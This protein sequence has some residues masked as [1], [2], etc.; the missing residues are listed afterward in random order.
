[1]EMFKQNDFYGIITKRYPN[2]DVVVDS[3]G[4]IMTL[5]ESDNELR[6]GYEEGGEVMEAEI[7][8]EVLLAPNGKPS[9][10]G[11]RQWHLVRTP[12]FKQWFGDWENSPESASKMVDL[13]GEP[14]V[15]Y[16]GTNQE[17]TVFRDDVGHWHDKGFYG[18]GFY[19]T[20]NTDPKWMRMAIGEAGY[21]GSKVL[22]CFIKTNTPFDFSTLTEYN[23]QDISYMGYDAMVFLYNIAKRFPELA[24]TITIPQN[25]WNSTLQEN[26]VEYLPISVIPPLVDKYKKLLKIRPTFENNNRD[27]VRSGYVKS[28]IIEY[29]NTAQGGKKDSWVSADWLGEY[30]DHLSD[31]E[32]EIMLIIDAIEKYDGLKA[33]YH[34]EGYTT[35][36]PSITDA[37]KKSHDGIKQGKSGDEIVVFESTQIKLADGSNKTFDGNNPDI[38]YV[39]GGSVG[40]KFLSKTATKK[41]LESTFKNYQKDNMSL[42]EIDKRSQKVG[43]KAQEGWRNSA[44]YKALHDRYK[45]DFEGESKRNPDEKID[46]SGLNHFWT[47]ENKERKRLEA[48]NKYRTGSPDEMPI[49]I[50][51]GLPRKF[52]GKYVASEGQM[53]LY[54]FPT[55]EPFKE[56]GVS[57]FDGIYDG[58]GKFV[59][60][61]TGASNSLTIGYNEASET[62]RPLYLVEGEI[63]DFGADDE[64]TLDPK[65]IKVI[66][67][68]DPK[69]VFNDIYS[70]AGFNYAGEEVEHPHTE[71]L[72]YAKGGSVAPSGK[73]SNLT[74]EQYKLVRTPEFIAWFGDWLN[75]PETASKVVD[76]NGEPLVVY[77][78]TNGTKEK[79]TSFNRNVSFFAKDKEFVEF[80]MAENSFSDGYINEF[81]LNFRKPFILE[82]GG[83]GWADMPISEIEQ[84]TDKDRF[85]MI[86]REFGVGTW[87]DLDDYYENREQIDLTQLAGFVKSKGIYDGLIAKDVME[88]VSGSMKTDDYLAFQPNQIKLAD[89]SNTTFDGSNLDIRFLKGG[90]IKEIKNKA[91]SELNFVKSILDKYKDSITPLQSRYLG[92]II[93]ELNKMATQ[94]DDL[95]NV[96]DDKL[97]DLRQ[98]LEGRLRAVKYGK[99]IGAS[100]KLY[101]KY[102]Y[103]FTDNYGLSELLSYYNSGNNL[104][105]T[106]SPLFGEKEVASVKWAGGEELQLFSDLDVKIVFDL[107]KLRKNSDIRKGTYKPVGGTYFGEYEL[108]I[109]NAKGKITD[110]IDWIEFRDLDALNYNFRLYK[111]V[112]TTIGE[113]LKKLGIEVREREKID[114]KNYLFGDKKPVYEKGG[115]VSKKGWSDDHKA[116]HDLICG[117]LDNKSM[118]VEERAGRLI[119]LYENE[120]IPHFKKEEQEIFEVNKDEMS[121]ELTGEHLQARTIMGEIMQHKR[122]G[123]IKAFCRLLKQ[124]I[125]K[126]EKYFQ[127]NLKNHESV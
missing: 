54:G 126:E 98:S 14:L 4:T 64:P 36:N 92:R 53:N 121:K 22:S 78:G 89:G 30:S 20:F 27:K 72:G 59:I 74:P 81:F 112:R 32:L 35:R 97:Y 114:V 17:F 44:E 107:Q 127:S 87:K 10:L 2:G 88:G 51:A 52:R 111:Q 123:D 99:N 118:P 37:I 5:P 21:Y 124:H 16:H 40:E 24:S 76:E 109:T 45:K 38:R 101:E 19:F 103:H 116:T 75:S 13:N 26:E 100:G 102:A 1:M 31:K 49:F 50:R 43:K 79:F 34:P 46:W 86:E 115:D 69:M 83:S 8:T 62:G 93:G 73:K 80:F 119:S 113:E 104:S 9:N 77:H 122:E 58:K 84:F 6:E 15:C 106:T 66:G 110:Y 63:N 117:M 85:E 108:V 91:L 39:K 120:L 47:A 105:L 11:E 29:D 71:E 33:M 96:W 82:L 55:G 60:A 125:E 23:G 90:D 95:G 28:E 67:V 7:D 61:D 65:T 18:A 41:H 57:V 56:S 42:E 12:E 25:K 70:Y 94:N 3:K 68:L 48:L